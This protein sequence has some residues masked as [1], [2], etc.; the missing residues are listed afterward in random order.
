MIHVII[1]IGKIS[2][3]GTSSTN[4]NNPTHP[5]IKKLTNIPAISRKSLNKGKNK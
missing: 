2:A 3:P 1:K 4:A 5:N